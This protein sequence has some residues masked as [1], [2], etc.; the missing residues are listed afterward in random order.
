[1]IIDLNLDQVMLFG[2]KFGW[3]DNSCMEGY[4]DTE[5]NECVL[6]GCVGPYIYKLPSGKVLVEGCDGW[7]IRDDE[8]YFHFGV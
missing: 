8:D 6:L 2:K 3:G 5:K 7:E 4:I 1:M